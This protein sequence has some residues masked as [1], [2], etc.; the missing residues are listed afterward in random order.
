MTNRSPDPASIAVLGPG[1]MGTGI[2]QVFATQGHE[3]SVIDV[4]ERP[5]GEAE[6]RFETLEA[7]VR[8]NVELLARHGQFEGDVGAVT[9]RIHGTR[10]PE[11]ALGGVD[12]LFEALPED[13]AV[14]RDGLAGLRGATPAN[15]VIATTTSSISLETLADAVDDP[16]RLL[17]THWLNPAFIVPLVEVARTEATDQDAVDATVALLRRV[18][19]EPVVCRDRPGF[20]GSRVQ[21]AA[22]NEAVRAYEEGVADAGEIDRALRSGVG[23]RMAVLGLLEF[24]DVGGVD[25]LYY[26]NEYLAEELGP[27][28]ENPESVVEKMEAGHGGL[29]DGRGYY[30]YDGV[31]DEELRTAVYEAMLALKGTLY[32]AESAFDEIFPSVGSRRS[33]GESRDE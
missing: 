26:V 10:D 23:F 19:K 4:K 28:F 25:I 24:I 13:P 30:D 6:E 15:T 20:I 1:R 29:S 32:D 3:V 27:R 22:M 31:D 9:D 11:D 12:W 16:G 17:I 18:G 7:T 21:A 14:K 5:P 8:S 2:A 33:A